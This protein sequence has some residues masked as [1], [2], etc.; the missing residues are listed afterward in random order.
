MEKNVHMKLNAFDTLLV[1]GPSK[2]I[3]TLSD[4]GDFIVLGKVEAR[5]QRKVLVGQCI[6]CTYFYIFCFNW[7]YTDNER[8]V[9]KCCDF[10]VFKN[11][12]CSGKLSVNTLAGHHF[13]SGIDTHWHSTPK[14]R[15]RLIGLG[16]IFL[17]LFIYFPLNYSHSYFLEPS[18]LLLWYL[19]RYHPMWLQP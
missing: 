2:K 5:L 11:Y 15:N 10:I 3:S 8:R 14:N 16:I 7:I 6:C 18:T 4:R 17:N 9:Y 19:R 12:L 1:Y 13:D